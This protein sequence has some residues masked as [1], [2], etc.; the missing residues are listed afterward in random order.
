MTVQ[1]QA[2][3]AAQRLVLRSP[4]WKHL[5]VVLRVLSKLYRRREMR[6]TPSLLMTVQVQAL[7]TVTLLVLGFHILRLPS[8][9]LP[10]LRK[11][12]RMR[13]AILLP[14]SAG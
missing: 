5:R 12:L 14:S 9:L 4:F 2:L 13:R 8:R 1:V 6:E 10:I 3:P 7:Q 11:W